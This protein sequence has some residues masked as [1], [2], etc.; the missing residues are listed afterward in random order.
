MSRP[1]LLHSLTEMSHL[2]R[3]CLE[4]AEVRTVAEIGSESGAHTRELLRFVEE[5]RGELWCVEPDPTFEVEQLDD[6]E[7]HLHLVRGLSPEALREVEPCDAYIVDGD[8]NYWTVSQELRHI[9]GSASKMPLVILHDVCWPSGRRDQYYAPDA[10]PPGAVQPHSWQLGSVPD[11]DEAVEAGF[12]GRG[13][14]AI[15]LHEGGERNGVLTAV[16]DFVGARSDLC[17]AVVPAIFG[18]G[19]LY[20]SAA[21]YAKSLGELLAP[22]DRNPLLLCLE[23]NRID[24]YLELLGQQDRALA[25]GLQQGRLLAEYDRSLTVAEAEA[26]ELR[27]EVAKLRERAASARDATSSPTS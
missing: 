3:G 12:R 4:A 26:A 27:L 8:H 25:L 21:P 20:P 7:D 23:R 10:L 1:L 13:G 15:A 22:L 24:L 11:R 5:R 2:V 6:E 18:L 14:F 16:E 19:V 9:S 17:L